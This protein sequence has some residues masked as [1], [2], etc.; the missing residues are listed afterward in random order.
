MSR[1]AVFGQMA[2]S[3]RE[4]GAA[5]REVLPDLQAA[6]DQAAATADAVDQSAERIRAR[7]NEVHAE[8]ST[9]LGQISEAV[10]AGMSDFG[11]E[12][13]MQL[14]ALE[15]GEK[16]VGE[17]MQIWGDAMIDLGQ[18]NETLREALKG[19][20]PRQFEERAQEIRRQVQ[21]G[22]ASAEE[23]FEILQGLGT[24]TAQNLARVVAALRDGKATLD[25]VIA[26]AEQAARE[27]GPD[28]VTGAAAEGL[29]ETLR[30]LGRE[31][32]TP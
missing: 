5:A 30:E 20:D 18:G 32:L 12:F 19:M 7:T 1:I 15:A 16:E 6:Q 22:Q 24:A 3:I 13:E 4:V 23:L 8:T 25:D 11:A 21:D 28:S 10:R 17:F 2:S 31:G 9:I 14:A 26:T 29:A 27:T